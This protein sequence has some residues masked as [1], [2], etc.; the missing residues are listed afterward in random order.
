[1][2]F[3][4]FTSLADSYDNLVIMLLFGR[5]IISLEDITPSLLSNE[6]RKRPNLEGCQD[7]GL[8]GQVENYKRRLS[9][10]GFEDYR[11]NF[12]ARG[13]GKV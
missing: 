9:V 11:L 4:F 13:K 2:P 1:M 5:N 7:F 6:I 10:K 8:I 3:Y 12:K